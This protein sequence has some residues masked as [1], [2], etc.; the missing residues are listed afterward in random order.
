MVPAPP[1]YLVLARLLPLLARLLDS[2]HA[3]LVQTGA[4]RGRGS[5]RR[6][7]ADLA[8][9]VTCF[10][11]RPPRRSALS[12]MRPTR[13]SRSY[14]ALPSS[15]RTAE[16]LSVG[17]LR[18]RSVLVAWEPR[19]VASVL[20]LTHMLPARRSQVII[21]LFLLTRHLPADPSA[22]DASSS[23]SDQEHPSLAATLLDT[24][25]CA[26]ADSPANLRVFE[27]AGGLEAVMKVLKTKGVRKDVRCVLSLLGFGAS[28]TCL[29]PRHSSASSAWSFSSS[30][31]S[32]SGMKLSGRLPR[33]RHR[34]PCPRHQPPPINATVVS[35]ALEGRPW[36]YLLLQTRTPRL[37]RPVRLAACRS[38]AVTGC[39]QAN[40]NRARPSDSVS[41][42][43]ASASHRRERPATSSRR[44]PPLTTSP[45]APF[46]PRVPLGAASQLLRARA[47]RRRSTRPTDSASPTPILP[48]SHRF[49]WDLRVPPP[50]AP[51][52]PLPPLPPH[53]PRAPCVR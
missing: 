11:Q 52:P 7:F 50:S 42:R 1:P 13:R 36:W 8:L 9:P 16:R 15:I 4:V 40:L 23:S 30:T 43:A 41:R 46:L 45:R 25:F 32:Q 19:R 39:L 33:P 35:A 27:D 37:P 38:W 18:S 34:P 53:P 49:P 10:S 29:P 22:L 51:R 5:S 20:L 17:G 6:A 12:S 3:Q 47:G 48:L 2:I 21:D 26:L 24:L 44:R 14:R 31:S 28:L